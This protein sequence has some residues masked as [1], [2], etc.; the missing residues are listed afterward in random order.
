MYHCFIPRR[1]HWILFDYL[2][3]SSIFSVIIR[4]IV[5]LAL[6]TCDKHWSITVVTRLEKLIPSAKALTPHWILWT[7]IWMLLIWNCPGL[8]F[9]HRLPFLL[10]FFS[11]HSKARLKSMKNTETLCASIFYMCVVNAHKYVSVWTHACTCTGQ[12][13]QAFSDN[14]L[15]LIA[16]REGPFMKFTFSAR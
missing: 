5:F 4:K 2:I 15:H 14:A 11:V 3:S 1:N 10:L 12:D 13:I 8:G 16:L 9:L 7:T 6:Y